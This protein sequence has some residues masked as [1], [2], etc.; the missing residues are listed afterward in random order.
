[1]DLREERN[2]CQS[3]LRRRQRRKLS[4]TSRDQGGVQG[5]ACFREKSRNREEGREEIPDVEATRG[6]I[7]QV[8][9]KGRICGWASGNLMT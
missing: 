4:A 6:Q 7:E 5:R 8:E 1:M 3:R 9:W 2:S